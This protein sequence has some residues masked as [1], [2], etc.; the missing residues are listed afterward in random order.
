MWNGPQI[1]AELLLTP[2]TETVTIGQQ[3]PLPAELCH[4]YSKPFCFYFMGM[5]S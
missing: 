1:E 5:D 4:W 3:G 2:E